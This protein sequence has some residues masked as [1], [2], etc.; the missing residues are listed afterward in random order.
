MRG[1]WLIYETTLANNYWRE[2]EEKGHQ[3]YFAQ[4][5]R[6]YHWYLPSPSVKGMSVRLWTMPQGESL[7]RHQDRIYINVEVEI[8]KLSMSIDEPHL[9]S[10]S[11]SS[12]MCRT[13]WNQSWAVIRSFTFT[14]ALWEVV[15]VVVGSEYDDSHPDGSTS[16]NKTRGGEILSTEITS[17][18]GG[19]G[20]ISNN[21]FNKPSVQ[22]CNAPSILN[23]PISSRSTIINVNC[24]LGTHPRGCCS[25]ASPRS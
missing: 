10:S 13:S 25:S 9:I 18:W 19:K 15:L 4:W 3:T 22:G 5:Q 2:S 17:S 23:Y 24:N 1:K 7:Q 16:F 20:N 8:Y 12:S 6:V 21:F 14:T 11:K